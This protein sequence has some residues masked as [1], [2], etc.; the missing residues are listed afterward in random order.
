[1]SSALVLGGSGMLGTA[2]SRQLKQVGIPHYVTTH[3]KESIRDDSSVY[4]DVESNKFPESFRTIAKS[5]Q[6]IINCIGKIPQKASIKTDLDLRKFVTVNSIFPHRLA[7]F[8]ESEGLKVI[9]IA[10]DCVFSGTRGM[11]RE[12][13]EHDASD[14]YG[15]SKSLGEVDSQDVLNI[16]CSIIGKDDLSNVSLYNWVVSQKD[17]SQIYG[18]VDHYW[19]GV[20]TRI[21]SELV[22]GLIREKEFFSGTFHFVPSDFVTKFELISSIAVKENREDLRI[23]KFSKGKIDRRLMTM[24]PETNKKLWNLA[25]YK[26]PLKIRDIVSQM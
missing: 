12:C 25:G 15:V 26:I 18:F 23:V 8:A 13:D 4:F 6:Y 20:S 16:R 1:M 22:A 11:Y 7:T 9:Q 5:T 3:R 10:T 19:N 17:N 2:V 24:F 14:T 21:F